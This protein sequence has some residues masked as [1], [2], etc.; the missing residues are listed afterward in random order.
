MDGV[1]ITSYLFFASFFD[2]IYLEIILHEGR[3]IS[4]IE[5]RRKADKYDIILQLIS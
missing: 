4:I 5:N 3:E 1:P 2:K